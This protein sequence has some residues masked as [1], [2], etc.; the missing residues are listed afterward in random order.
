MTYLPITLEFTL[1]MVSDKTPLGYLIRDQLSENL[2]YSLSGEGIVQINKENNEVSKLYRV[3]IDTGAYMSLL[4]YSAFKD[5][6]P[7]NYLRYT[8]F[9]IQRIAE[10]GIECAVSKCKFILL[11]SKMRES[12]EIESWIAFS[13]GSKVPSLLGMKNI[14]DSYEHHWKPKEKKV[15]IIFE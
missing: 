12:P 11:D 2:G 5:V 9:G 8:L 13:L 14:L 3:K 7:S 15:K 6:N 1:R 10:C 4:P